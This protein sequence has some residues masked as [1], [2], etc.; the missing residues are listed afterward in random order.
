MKIK[1]TAFENN[2]NIPKK[3]TCQGDGINPPLS[4]S[5]L[6]Q[7]TKSLVLI[8]DDPDATIGT[9]VHW[10]IFNIDPIINNLLENSS[11]A[12]SVLGKNSASLNEYVAPCP[13]S[14][15]HRYFFKLYALD[16]LL[17][18]TSKADKKEA[19]EAMI[20]HILDRAELI[21]TYQ[22]GSLV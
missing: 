22:K 8:M 20:G 16:T 14:G 15:I 13:P 18:L 5:D 12:G 21:G 19:E 7:N 3:Y 9:F 2:K 11:P 6:P 10:L 4:F 17:N 1:S